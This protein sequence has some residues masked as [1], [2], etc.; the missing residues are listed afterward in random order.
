MTRRALLFTLSLPME[1]LAKDPELLSLKP[2]GWMP[3]NE[4]LP[5]L[6]YRNVFS[7]GASAIEG[8]FKHH[9]WQPQWRNGVYPFHHYHSTAHEVLGFA[10]GEAKLLL[11]GEKPGGV[12]VTVRAGDV[13]VLPCGTGHCKVSASSDF[14]VVGAYALGQSW[15]LCRA[16]PDDAMQQRMRRLAFP[17]LDPLGAQLTRWWP[18]NKR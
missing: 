1:L 14:L 12:E 8:I 16:A 11:G 7:G 3:N 15:D 18:T 4:Y 9:G 10:A 5:V 13:A 2:N 17:D 6:L